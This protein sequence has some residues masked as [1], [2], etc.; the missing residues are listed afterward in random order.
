M[1]EFFCEAV[2]GQVEID[3]VVITEGEVKYQM[4]FNELED[5][6]QDVLISYLTERGLYD[7]TLPRLVF[8]LLNRYDHDYHLNFLKSLQTFI[9]A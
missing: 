8:L 3:E 2:A 6:V 1:L 7:D 5:K 9:K 4:Y